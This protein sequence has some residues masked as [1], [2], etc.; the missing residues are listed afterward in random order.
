VAAVSNLLALDSGTTSCR[1]I[2]SDR[3]GGV[4]GVARKEFA[5]HHPKPGW[6]EHGPLDIRTAQAGVAV[7][8]LACAGLGAADIAARRAVGRSTGWIEAAEA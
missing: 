7:E 8:A 2:A 1:G 5:Q 4:R 6:V 3:D